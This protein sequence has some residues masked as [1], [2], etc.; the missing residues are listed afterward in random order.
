VL[1]GE[2]ESLGAKLAVEQRMGESDAGKIDRCGRAP[3]KRRDSA[4]TAAP[5]IHSGAVAISQTS[6]LMK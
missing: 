2:L 1:A 4:E 6:V 5:T 3:H